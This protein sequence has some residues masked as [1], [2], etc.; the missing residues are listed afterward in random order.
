MSAREKL[1]QATFYAILDLDYTPA[2]RAVE[3]ATALVRG[4]ADLLQLR[5]KNAPLELL[6]E[7][8]GELAALCAA[9]GTPFI[10]NDH[11]EVAARS[12]ADGVHVGQEDASVA[13]ARAVL[14]PGRLVGRSTHSLRQAEAAAAEGADYI[15]FGPLHAT[16]T[17]P[18]RPPI[19]LGDI[20]EVHRRVHL[21]IFCIGGI[22]L[23]NLGE[24][25]R[26]GARRVVIVSEC[27]QAS[28]CGAY[29]QEVRRRLHAAAA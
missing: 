8:A 1:Q 25:V 5:G 20:A 27:L 2:A 15:G 7:L 19:G 17:K 26:A 24:V 6:G 11:L 13:Q 12:G 4:G 29:L 23:G 28:D 3:Q 9:G 18:G 22:K 21:P 16:Q 14:G 10:V